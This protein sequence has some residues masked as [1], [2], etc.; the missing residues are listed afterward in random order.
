MKNEKVNKLTEWLKSQRNLSIIVICAIA[1]LCF[2]MVSFGV[3]Y[4]LHK[5]HRDRYHHYTTYEIYKETN[6]LVYDS[7][8]LSLVKEV[9]RYIAKVSN[10]NSALNGLVVVD[11]CIEHD[12]DICFVLAQGEQESHFGTQGL[13]RK[14]NSVFNV[15]AF[16]GHAYNE[17][18]KNGKYA[19]PNDCISPYLVLLKRN[20]MVDGKT[21][22]D[23]LKKFVNKDGARYASAENY[24]QSLMDKITKIKTTTEIDNLYQALR[25]QRLI[26]GI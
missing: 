17:I 12:I 4:G 20:Y 14:T 19:H 7:I 3:E 13:A 9:D 8:K 16:D 25:K 1:L 6:H 11:Q 5:L 2:G 22:Y 26:V 23:L 24:E 10:N 18:N 21:E 15:Y